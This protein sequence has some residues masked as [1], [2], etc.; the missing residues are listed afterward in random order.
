MINSINIGGVIYDSGLV[1]LSYLVAVIAS[2]TT[3]SL[4]APLRESTHTY[5]WTV[6]SAFSLGP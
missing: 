3:L 6:D 2:Y 5:A 4:R 1:L